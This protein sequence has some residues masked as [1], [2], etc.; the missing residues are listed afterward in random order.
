MADLRDSSGKNGHWEN[1]MM[2]RMVRLSTFIG[3]C[4]YHKAVFITMICRIAIWS[5]RLSVPVLRTLGRMGILLSM[6]PVWLFAQNRQGAFVEAVSLRDGIQD[7]RIAA[8]EQDKTGFLWVGTAQGLYRYDGY[9]FRPFFSNASDTGSLSHDV[10]SYLF[11]DRR[12]AL[13]ACTGNGICRFDSKKSVFRRYFTWPDKVQERGQAY[14]LEACD[15][16]Q[17]HIWL[18]NHVNDIYVLDPVSGQAN[19][20]F[21]PNSRM[22]D[23]KALCKGSN[24]NI[25]LGHNSGIWRV[26]AATGASRL[27]AP[28]RLDLPPPSAVREEAPDAVWV[29]FGRTTIGC[30]H[31]R[32][33]SWTY[34]SVNNPGFT[35][36]ILP[37]G[38]Q[39][40]LLGCTNMAERHH[41]KTGKNTAVFLP[42]DP[43]FEA[44]VNTLFRDRAGIV[45]FGTEN[46]LFKLDPFLQGFQKVQ[47]HGQTAGM[48]DNDM[49]GVYTFPQSP[50]LFAV[51]QHLNAIFVLRDQPEGTGFV[52]CVSTKP[53]TQPNEMMR[54]R[55]GTVWLVCAEQLLRFDPQG[56][57]LTPAPPLPPLNNGKYLLKHATEDFQGRLWLSTFTGHICIFDPKTGRYTLLGPEQGLHTKRISGIWMDRDGRYAWLGT[58]FGGFVECELATLQFRHFDEKDAP[59]LANSSFCQQDNDGNVWIGGDKGLL[60]Y[61]PETKKFELVLSRDNGLPANNLD[62]GLLDKNGDLWWG[63][64]DR[65]VRFSP[66]IRAF[67]IFDSR[68][69]IGRTPYRLMRFTE[70][71]ATGE[72][73]MGL[74]GAFMRWHPDSLRRNTLPPPVVNVSCRYRNEVVL[75]PT[76]S[77]WGI[78]FDYSDNSFSMEFA[79]L[80]FTLPEENRYS[81]RLENFSETWSPP[82]R[83]RRFQANFVPPGKYKLH[84]RAANNDGVW[85]EPTEGIVVEVFPDWWQTWWFRILVVSALLGLSYGIYRYRL[86]AQLH[87]ESMQTRSKELE[88]QQLINEIALL[89]TQVNPHFLFN[90]LSILSSLVQVNAELSEQ[91]ID[92]L[93]RSYRYILE[94]KDQALVPLRTELEFIHAYAFLLKIRFE[95][96]FDLIARLPETALDQYKIAPLTLQLLVE[97]AVKHNRMSVQEPL[98]LEVFIENDWLLVKNHLRPRFQQA[99]STGT[100][101]NNIIS[102]YALLTDRSVWAGEQ[103]DIFVVRV[104]L[105]H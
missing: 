85:S 79:A 98:V 22:D 33:G 65:L 23:F 61:T 96:K 99:A 67:K 4:D 83:E 94:Q 91:F 58:D 81:W 8:I 44:R 52:K 60:C 82:D 57:R 49:V 1:K 17:G 50:Y 11:N 102:R 59:G 45:W 41:L 92:Q 78:S 88:R 19:Q 9:Q 90:S 68:Y 5:E 104:P 63:L 3:H 38:P 24:N 54:A 27:F 10:I 84:I 76:D 87:L 32:K 35:G 39:S 62:G 73:F 95:N 53:Y 100:G 105:M 64:S 46:G 42:A 69:G 31:P 2:P 86:R 97:N 34:F 43:E 55:D 51:S 66:S 93:A 14:V 48:T 40:I 72:L 80:N 28:D 20:W 18:R 56:F 74:R 6:F 71:A 15:D 75:A 47:V 103:G 21:P 26:N 12:R 37:E 25:W 36:E 16:E 7:S 30:L 70:D 29:V 13:W 89:K 77:V 101:L